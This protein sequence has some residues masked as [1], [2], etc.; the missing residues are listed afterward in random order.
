VETG[1]L[2]WKGASGSSTC[3]PLSRLTGSATLTTAAVIGKSGNAA[4]AWRAALPSGCE[5]TNRPL[6]PRN[7][8]VAAMMMV[9][10][11][12]DTVARR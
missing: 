10:V 2:R 3:R 11:T 9:L 12:G 6:S 5:G 1:S 8:V 4:M 7:A